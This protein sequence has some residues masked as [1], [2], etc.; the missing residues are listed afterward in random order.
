VESEEAT[1]R[2][3]VRYV[4]IRSQQRRTEEFIRGRSWS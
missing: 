1:L 3:T 2:V 4:I